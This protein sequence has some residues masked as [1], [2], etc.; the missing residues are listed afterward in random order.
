[1]IGRI[2]GTLVI[3]ALL[4][5]TIGLP[6]TDRGR[7]GSEATVR[8][9]APDAIGTVGERLPRLSLRDLEGAP[10]TLGDFR[11]QRVIL[12]FERSLDWSAFT[13]ARLVELV[14]RL[15]GVEDLVILFVLPDNQLNEKTRLFIAGNWLSDRVTFLQDPFSAS[16]DLLRLRRPDPELMETGVPHPATYVLDRQGVVRFVDIRADY[17]IWLDA[18]LILDALAEIP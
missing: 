16:I 13:K 10:V 2:L 15:D 17:Q 6:Y 3:G 1:M 11:G 18:Q 14:Q 7:R 8:H 4:A 12:T 9:D 5:L